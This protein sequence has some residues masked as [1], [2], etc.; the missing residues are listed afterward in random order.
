MRKGGMA[1]RLRPLLILI[2]GKVDLA[3]VLFKARAL[4]LSLEHVHM[5][6]ESGMCEMR[7][8]APG[9]AGPTTAGPVT[10]GAP[11]GP[12]PEGARRSAKRSV[13]L[14]RMHLLDLMERFLGPDSEPVRAAIRGAQSRDEVLQ[15]LTQ[16][17][18][19]VREIGGEERV[20][21][22]RERVLE[23]LPE[24]VVLAGSA[25]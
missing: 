20:L 22:V 15:V 3:Q 16:C 11:G 4:G 18:E 6:L 17:L 5:L 23:L 14:A 12:A 19:V 24:A 1:M 2:D 8:T 13:A 9:L 21:V 25:R 10:V 7:A